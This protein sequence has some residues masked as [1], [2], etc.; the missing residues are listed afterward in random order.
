MRV[1]APH[2]LFFARRASC[3]I[4]RPISLKLLSW[5]SASAASASRLLSRPNHQRR[6]FDTEIRSS[7]N[8]TSPS[9]GNL[10]LAARGRA[11]AAGLVPPVGEAAVGENDAGEFAVFRSLIGAPPPTGL[12]QHLRRN[13]PQ[14]PGG[15]V[16]SPIVQRE[17]QYVRRRNSFR[18][19]APSSP[20]VRQIRRRQAPNGVAVAGLS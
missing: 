1:E 8:K 18:R 11:F 19:E 6:I 15:C 17:C 13:R 5:S 9:S 12:E 10:V 2:L 16:K 3:R 14:E 20:A 4:W 7:V